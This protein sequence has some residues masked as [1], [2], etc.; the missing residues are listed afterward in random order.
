MTSKKFFFTA[1]I[2]FLI[3]SMS[4]IATNFY[5]NEFGLFRSR[6]NIR[7]WALEKSSKYLL[8]FRYIPE[9]F[10]GILVGPSLSGNV[11]TKKI[12]NDKI[13]N[14]SLNGGNASELMYVS[15]N[16]L[17]SK[18]IKCLIICLHPYITASSGTKGMQIDKKEY[19]GSLFSF[20]PFKFYK[21]KIKTILH[22]E[23]DIFHSSEWGYNDFNMLLKN[24]VDFSVI[25]ENNKNVGK[26]EI[27]VNPVAYSDLQNMVDLAHKNNVKVLAYYYP[28]FHDWYDNYVRSGEWG[29]YTSKIDKIF[30]DNDVVWDM[31]SP[32]YQYI[33][34]DYRSYTDGHLSYY[35]ADLVVSS[36]YDQLIN[37]S[38]L[39]D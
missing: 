5:L 19:W 23:K 6:E 29:R 36:I 13:Y 26:E 27:I 2:C 11:D 24:K 25:V 38:D 34:K 20:F 7:I 16:V 33:N 21:R 31:N 35:G 14:M 32:E 17:N 8:S 39:S 28:I 15:E 1:S 3:L 37:L 22:P 18:N 30:G 12:K 10:N 9:N 4:I